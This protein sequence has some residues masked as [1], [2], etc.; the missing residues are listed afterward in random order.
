MVNSDQSTVIV[1]VRVG[2]I[3]FVVSALSLRFLSAAIILLARLFP[4]PHRNIYS[5]HHHLIKCV[6]LVEQ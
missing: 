4:I 3:D 6:L 2:I 5:I 1:L